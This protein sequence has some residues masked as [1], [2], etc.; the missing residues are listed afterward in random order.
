MNVIREDDVVL[1]LSKWEANDLRKM[2]NRIKTQPS[3]SKSEFSIRE[4][5]TGRKIVE[6][7]TERLIKE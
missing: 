6:L 2:L 1:V 4:K 5:R 3:V 7:V